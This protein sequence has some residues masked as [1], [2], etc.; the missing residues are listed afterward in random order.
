MCVCNL[1]KYIS[2][3]GKKKRKLSERTKECDMVTEE[4]MEGFSSLKAEKQLLPKHANPHTH[5]QTHTNAHT[6]SADV[7][8][9]SE[10]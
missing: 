4:R 9:L 3:R 2:T 7:N 6:M 5:T 10:S 1:R 8:S